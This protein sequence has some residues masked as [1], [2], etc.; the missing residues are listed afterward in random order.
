[1]NELDRMLAREKAEMGERF[2]QGELS[3]ALTQA[4]CRDPELAAK[5][6]DAAGLLEGDRCAGD[7][8]AAL[9][10]T[11]PVLF[12][13][14]P[15][16]SARD[17]STAEYARAKARFVGRGN[18]VS[19]LD[20]NE[21]LQRWND[22]KAAAAERHAQDVARAK[23][24]KNALKVDDA[25]Y[26]GMRA[27]MTGTHSSS[28]KGRDFEVQQG[29]RLDELRRRSDGRRPGDD[30]DARRGQLLNDMRRWSRRGG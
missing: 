8:V 23:D 21:R 29:R 24:G 18:A 1:M 4:R 13:P 20:V 7:V 11:K 16:K 14:P 6:I 17:M 3:Q 25:E 22:V 30:G 12:E 27:E 10:R 19:G 9:Q 2:A 15:A 28:S 26:Q 5:Y